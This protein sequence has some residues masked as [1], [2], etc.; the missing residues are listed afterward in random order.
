MSSLDYQKSDL[1]EPILKTDIYPVESM[2]NYPALRNAF[3]QLRAN[4]V[5]LNPALVTK[6]IQG[7]EQDFIMLMNKAKE[8]LNM[9]KMVNDAGNSILME[10]FQECVF[11]Y[12]VLTPLIN[13][14]TV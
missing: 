2:Y 11:G 9:N 4:V 6:C 13:E 10:L 14:K 1:T 8:F 5:D 12:Y 3:I 7:T